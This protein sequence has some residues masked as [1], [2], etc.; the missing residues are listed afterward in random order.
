MTDSMIERVARAIA[1]AHR[2]GD[3]FIAPDGSAHKSEPW[4]GFVDHARAAIA[5]MR[6]PTEAMASEGAFAV[7]GLFEP[8]AVAVW[9]AMTDAALKERPLTSVG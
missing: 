8:G 3:L 2:I 5:A 4:Q 6:E 9:Q 7:D 1:R